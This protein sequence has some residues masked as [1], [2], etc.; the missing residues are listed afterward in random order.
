[1]R[2]NRTTQQQRTISTVELI[3]EEGQWVGIE[4]FFGGNFAVRDGTS[5]ESKMSHVVCREYALEG[6]ISSL[7]VAALR[8]CGHD[9]TDSVGRQV[10]IVIAHKATAGF[11]SANV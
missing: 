7:F 9:A 2:F 11:G 10:I 6:N 3:L 4:T 5:L 1:M 8:S